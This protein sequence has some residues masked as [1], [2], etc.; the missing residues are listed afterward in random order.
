MRI[1][2]VASAFPEYYYKQE[3]LTEAL[4]N[5]WRHRLT[6]PDILDRLDESMQVEGRYLVEPIDYYE[7]L[8]TWDKRTTPGSSMRSNSASNLSARRSTKPASARKTSA[9]SSSPP[10]PA[11]PRP[12][13]MRAW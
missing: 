9:R 2:S 3:L 7:K 10:L 6:N 5:D 1:A 8:T 4:K 12:P 11:S 13:S